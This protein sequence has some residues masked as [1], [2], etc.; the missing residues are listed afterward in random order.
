MR[1]IKTFYKKA[2]Q[3]FNKSRPIQQQLIIITSATVCIGMFSIILLNT[4]IS[5]VFYQNMQMHLL[6]DSGEEI[7]G[8]LKGDQA[9]FYDR[10]AKIESDSNLEIEIF[11]A[12][13]ALLYDTNVNRF[14]EEWLEGANIDWFQTMLTK[15]SKVPLKII[16]R[17]AH[18]VYEI[19]QDAAHNKQYLTYTTVLSNGTVVT[20]NSLLDFVNN[21][22]N[23]T[24][25]HVSMIACTTFL[26]III[27]LYLFV[28]RFTNP[29][30]EMNRI[31]R[32]M[33]NM[34]FSQKCTAKTK[35]ELSELAE[36]INTLSES[37]DRTLCDLQNKNQQLEADIERE[38]Q[39]ETMRKEFISS[40]SHE[41]KTPIAIVQGYAEGLKLGIQT[42]ASVNDDYCDII[43]EETHKMNRLVS[44]LLELSKYEGGAYKLDC[45]VFSVSEFLEESIGSY[46]ILARE[47]D[48]QLQIHTQP[49]QYG[50]GD[51]SQLEVVLHN[52][53]SNALSHAD[54]E[55]RIEVRSEETATGCR[56]T[57]FNTGDPIPE[58]DLP[59]L[60]ISFYRADKSHSRSQGRYGLGLSISKAIMDMHRASYGVENRENGVAFYFE[61]GKADN[62]K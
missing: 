21:T 9:K 3:W 38:R 2:S 35:N 26:L 58:E 55:R 43:I 37:L 15:D 62:E 30:R 56:I 60:W 7:A 23:T 10:I 1:Y 51:P 6:S 25:R 13:G 44:G 32:S 41:L 5:S 61:I 20:I 4:R 53:V 50:Y 54:G 42:N 16:K 24:T 34:D 29:I 36:N 52:F 14:T 19:R 57:V 8:L 28:R 18:G 33:A 46:D 27:T 47:K 59:N 45:R 11:N 31:T 49:G 39:L 40:A 17:D 12:D 22:A 48:I